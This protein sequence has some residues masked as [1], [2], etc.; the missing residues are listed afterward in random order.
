MLCAEYHTWE[1]SLELRCA[2]K[3][4]MRHVQQMSWP[5]WTKYSICRARC[6]IKR[7]GSLFT[8]QEESPLNVLNHKPLPFLTSLFAPCTYRCLSLQDQML[9]A[10]APQTTATQTTTLHICKP[11]ATCS[12]PSCH[13]SDLHMVLSQRQKSSPSSPLPTGHHS[14]TQ[15]NRDCDLS[16]ECAGYLYGS[17]E[18]IEG[19]PC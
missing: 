15:W 6:K 14:N 2:G 4:E 9:G 13:M 7:Q 18:W 17:R 1:R 5:G 10:P 16:L 11:L 12:T 19:P 3:A 8:K